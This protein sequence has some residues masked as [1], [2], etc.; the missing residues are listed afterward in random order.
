MSLCCNRMRDRLKTFTHEHYK[1]MGVG[2]GLFG[3]AIGRLTIPDSRPSLSGSFFI[4]SHRLRK[5]Q[6]RAKTSAYINFCNR[7]YLIRNSMEIIN[8]R[9]LLG[10]G[11]K[12]LAC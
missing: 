3:Q 11:A 4:R 7:V 5:L 9:T 2:V 1:K 6:I 10:S 12:S 8:L